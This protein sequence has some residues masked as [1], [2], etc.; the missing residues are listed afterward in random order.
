MCDPDQNDLNALEERLR[1]W[2]PCRGELR[3]DRIPAELDQAASRNRPIR[4]ARRIP[5]LVRRSLSFWI[6]AVGAIVIPAVA[7]YAQG[8]SCYFTG[9]S[10]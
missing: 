4:G 8:N 9:I 2:I 5:R 7:C 6:L 1:S 3:R 10:E